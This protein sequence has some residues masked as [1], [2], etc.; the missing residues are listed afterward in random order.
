MNIE[1][2]AF[3]DQ[4]KLFGNAYRAGNGLNWP[5]V[6]DRPTEFRLHDETDVALLSEQIKWHQRQSDYL[7]YGF[8]QPERDWVTAPDP[9]T[10]LLGIPILIDEDVPAHHLRIVRPSGT[11]D[12]DAAWSSD[13]DRTPS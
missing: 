11:S 10:A 1:D 4:R 13:D 2:Y 3:T 8:G 12:I 6:E 7:V 9:V 5:T